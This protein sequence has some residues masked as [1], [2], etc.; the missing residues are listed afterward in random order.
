MN[1]T[2]ILIMKN[3]YKT[4]TKNKNFNIIVIKVL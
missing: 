3:I 2:K 1:I 4:R